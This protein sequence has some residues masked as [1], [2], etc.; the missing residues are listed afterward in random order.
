MKT[1]KSMVGGWFS[2]LA[3]KLGAVFSVWL[4]QDWFLVL[5]RVLLCSTW[6]FFASLVV[7]LGPLWLLL[8]IC[9]TLMLGNALKM[10]FTVRL[11]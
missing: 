9:W 2:L 8:V 7:L 6:V 5:A 3:L 10:I 4:L 1:M 11:V